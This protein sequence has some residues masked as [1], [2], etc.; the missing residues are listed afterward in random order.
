MIKFAGIILLI[1]SGSVFAKDVKVTVKL[2][3][4][5]AISVTEKGGDE[6]YFSVTTYPKNARATYERVP[7]FPVHWLAK[8]LENIKGV[9]LFERSF[10]E[11]DG[12]QVILSLVEQDIPPWNIDDHLG[13]VK[14]TFA[15]ENGRLNEKWS[16]PNYKDETSVKQR[17]S[18][19]RTKSYTFMGEGGEYRVSLSLHKD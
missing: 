2:D 4:I 17:S 15:N 11:G 5:E 3:S 8:S 13:S 18:T 9:V 7:M 19:S 16:I 14:L 10:T 6:I 12:A 1:A